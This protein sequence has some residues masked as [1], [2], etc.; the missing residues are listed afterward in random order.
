MIVELTL[1][2]DEG[3]PFIMDGAT[4]F[5]TM[6]VK[7]GDQIRISTEVKANKVTYHVPIGEKD[8]TI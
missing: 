2:T 5:I 6:T 1:L 4:C 7:D 3:K 8:E